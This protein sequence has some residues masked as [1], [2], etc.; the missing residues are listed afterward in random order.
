MQAEFTTFEDKIQ[1]N[2]NGKIDANNAQDFQNQILKAFQMNTKV[3]LNLE[4]VPYMSSAGLRA[5][6]IGEK[7][8][9]SK[10]GSFTIINVNETVMEVLRVTGLNKQKGGLT[11]L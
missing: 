4:G 10:G 1:I 3:I 5:L 2:V 9:N 8:A 6:I 11:I 7:T